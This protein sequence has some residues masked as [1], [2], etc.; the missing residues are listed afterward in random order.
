MAARAA[1]GALALAA[2]AGLSGCALFGVGSRPAA[3]P[4]RIARATATPGHGS[5]HTSPATTR[6]PSTSTATPVPPPPA[7]TLTPVPLGTVVAEGDVA[8]PKGSI[9]YHYRVVSTGDNMYEAQFSGF[10]STVPIPVSAT[11]LE[12][13]PS[14]GDGLTYHGLGD[15][16]LGGPTTAPA[17]PSSASLGKKPSFLTTLVTYSSVQ[18][19]DG[20]PIELGPNKVLAVDTVHWSIPARQSNVRPVDGGPQRGAQGLV[21]QTTPSGAPARYRVAPGDTTDLV[22]ER[23][24]IPREYLVWLNQEQPQVF[25]PRQQLYSSTTLNLDPDSL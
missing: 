3:A 18:S 19:G 4:E 16:D 24:G 6:P 25:D 21:T 7:P 5:A 15:H 22:A 23:F 12:I 11:F 17:P 9:H 20:V 2:L 13:P 1:A 14:V 8:S 10:T